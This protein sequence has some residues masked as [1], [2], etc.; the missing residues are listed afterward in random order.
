[1]VQSALKIGTLN[2][3]DSFNFAVVCFMRSKLPPTSKEIPFFFFSF[4]SDDDFSSISDSKLTFI[5][6]IDLSIFGFS[7]EL[8]I[9]AFDFWIEAKF[10]FWFSHH[11]ELENRVH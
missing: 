10:R 7:I 11:L 4:L 2:S 5:F 1:L 8:F 3:P 6:S 9:Y